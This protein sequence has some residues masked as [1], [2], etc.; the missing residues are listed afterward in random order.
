M[1]LRILHYVGWNPCWQLRCEERQLR[2]VQEGQRPC[3]LTYRSD[4]CVVLGR[5]NKSEEWVHAQAAATDGVPVL[6]R[7]SGG[8]AVVLTRDVLNYSFVVPRGQL[9]VSCRAAALGGLPVTARYIDFFRGLVIRALGPA[10]GSFTA[11]GTSDISLN[12][13]KISGNAQRISAGAVLHHGTLMLRCPLAE[14][15]RYLP[16]PPNRSDVAHRGFLTGLREEGLKCTAT[17]LERWLAAEL[18]ASLAQSW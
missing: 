1:R 14:I 3:C 18:A 13:R 2:R 15:E 7:I 11:T 4:L 6:R 12:G 9:E 5:N 10:G 16:L 17:E 8:G